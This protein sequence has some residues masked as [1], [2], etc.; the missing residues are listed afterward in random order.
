MFLRRLKRARL[1]A[2]G[3]EGLASSSHPKVAGE[4]EDAQPLISKRCLRLRACRRIYT[5]VVCDGLKS[6]A[7]G[8]SSAQLERHGFQQQLH[9]QAVVI[10]RRYRR[11]QVHRWHRRHRWQQV[12]PR[13]I[14]RRYRW[15]QVHR[16]HRKHRWQQHHSG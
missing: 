4:S 16:W 12:H 2:R 7:N 8:T 15:H 6:S 13:Q 9:H 14:H 11:H 3:S 10:H 1:H 5:R